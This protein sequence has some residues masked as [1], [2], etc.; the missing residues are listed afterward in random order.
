MIKGKEKKITIESYNKTAE[1]YYNTVSSFEILP[2]L[3]TFISIV[4]PNGRVLDLGCGP[5]HHSRIFL[6][7]G[8]QVDGIDLS[9]GM[10]AIAKKEVSGG[11]FQVM[12]ILDLKFKKDAFDGIWASASLLHIPKRNL[13][14]VIRELK[15]LLVEKGIL[16]ISLKKGEG[17]EV[18][19]DKRYGGVD[20]YYVYYETDEIEKI[21]V[22]L[23]FEIVENE[24]KE[25]RS[26][27]DTNPWIHIFCVK[28]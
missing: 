5:G 21:L 19:K 28:K 11:N 22:D 16:Y 13:K 26:F 3:E 6:E 23:D 7:N 24:Q 27:Y 10:I 17:S 8:F 12:D 14:K 18:I 1:E 2:E 15:K 4:K 20:K 25:M 9:T